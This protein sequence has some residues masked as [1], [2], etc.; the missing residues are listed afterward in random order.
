[1]PTQYWTSIL[2][3]TPNQ[4]CGTPN[5]KLT[6]G[7]VREA[8]QLSQDTFRGWRSALAPLNGR[9]GYTPCF[10]LADLL[11]LAIVKTIVD[12]A[13][14]RISALGPVAPALFDLTNQT[15]WP[16][17]ERSLLIM[18]LRAGTLSL[19]AE[20]QSPRTGV[21][22]LRVA[23]RPILA[24]LDE[25]LRGEQRGDGQHVLR[26]PLT[27]IDPERRLAGGGS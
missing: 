13:G 20:T 6:P 18:D 16:L 12:G 19:V 27:S 2:G 24:S 3:L 25:W 26:F 9:S 23:C 7:Q 22:D 14:V 8:L 10:S 5:L 15:A 1:M 21:V 11:A 17:L 4:T